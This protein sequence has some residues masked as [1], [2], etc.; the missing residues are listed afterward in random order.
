MVMVRDSLSNG[1]V[2]VSRHCILDGHFSHL[3]VVKI[4]NVC[5]KRPKMNELRPGLAHLKKIFYKKLALGSEHPLSLSPSKV[6]GVYSVR[7][8][9]RAT[10]LFAN[11]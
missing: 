6:R 9:L 2:F 5:L 7:L 11:P 10:D 1:R 8:V 3:F 4:C